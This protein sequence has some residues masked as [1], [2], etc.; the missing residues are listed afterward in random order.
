MD[1]KTNAAFRKRKKNFQKK[2]Q[3]K[4]LILKKKEKCYNCGKERHFARE[5]RSSKA[6]YA[7]TD[8]LKK[9]KERRA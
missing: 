3:K 1:W 5:C 2:A 9:E 7:K 8:N 4:R 6:N